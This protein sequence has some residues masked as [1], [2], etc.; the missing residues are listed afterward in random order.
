LA[1]HPSFGERD[2]SSI[3]GGTLVEALPSNVRPETPAASPLL[4]SLGMT[5]T[6]GP[7]TAADDPYAPLPPERQGS[8]GRALPGVAHAIDADGPDVFSQRSEGEI[9]VRG[10]L[11]M[12]GLYKRERFETFTTDGWYSTGD[13]GWFDDEGFLHFT[14]RGNA[15]IKT[16]GSN[17]SPEE[18]EA[19]IRVLPGVS[20][21]FVLGL[22]HPVRGEEV[23]AAIVVRPG[24]T[25]ADGEVV[26]HARGELAS[27]KVPRHVCLIDES[28]VPLLPTGKVD[29]TSLV[30]LFDDRTS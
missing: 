18:V 27:Y 13:R 26:S 6:G 17:V 24:S 4:A 8:F 9:H 16:A 3:R 11:V 10:P 21:V 14:G 15:M 23:A 1:D 30:H 28:Q 25:L 7:H 20:D 5:E 19:T 29:R 22:P 2:L 12:D